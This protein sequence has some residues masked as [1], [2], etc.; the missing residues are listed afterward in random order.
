MPD[1]ATKVVA[2]NRQASHEYFLLDRFEAGIALLGTE[3]KSIR[4]GGINLRDAYVRVAGREAWLL[5]AHISPYQPAG[6][7]AGHEPRRSRKLLLHR[8]ELAQLQAAL[9]Q[10]GL[11]VVPTR[12]LLR[13]GR[14]KL[15]I[16]LAKGK[17][18][19]DKRETIAKRDAER[20]MQRAMRRG[21]RKTP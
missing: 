17:K 19:Y 10:K 11:T 9:Q 21:V 13:K 1:D 12:L 2:T 7:Q 20:E 16:A 8:R 15:E 14:A 18:L 4:A 6:T 3:I 5:N